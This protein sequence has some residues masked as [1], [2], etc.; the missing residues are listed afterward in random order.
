MPNSS[1]C[2][3]EEHLSKA[4]RTALIIT[5]TGWSNPN[6]K[7]SR[8]EGLSLF[9]DDFQVVERSQDDDAGEAAKEFGYHS[10]GIVALIQDEEWIGNLF[11]A[12]STVRPFDPRL[13]PVLQAFADQAAI[14]IANAR[15]F[16]DLDAALERQTAMTEVLDAVSTSRLDLQP[17]YDAVVHHANRLCNGTGAVIFV[18]DGEMLR[19]TASGGPSTGIVDRDLPIDDSTPASEAALTGRAVHIA[20]W[21]EVPADQYRDSPARLSGRRSVLTVPMLRNG[22]SVGVVGFSR[23]EPGGFTEA[24]ISLLQA[25]ANQ[26]A[27]AVDNARL[28]AELEQRNSE[29]SESLEL[30]TATS[31]ILE[32]I[33][34]NPGDLRTVLEGIVKKASG[35]CGA[36]DGHVVLRVD[37]AWRIEAIGNHPREWL[38]ARVPMVAANERASR[39][40]TPVFIDDW[41]VEVRDSPIEAASRQGGLRSF[42]TIALMQDDEWLGNLGLSRQE[43]RPFDAKHGVILQAFADQAAIAITNARLFRQL[44]EQ[45][46]IAEEANAAKGSFLATMS[47]EP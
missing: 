5:A 16:N 38:G 24:E 23:E 42:V 1:P 45:T 13:G 29:L 11:V 18:R 4:G 19:P 43:V 26:A 25:F 28:L 27:I 9:F 2:I 36:D 44:E 15:L 17:V 20:D 41:T 40:H 12:R 46:R 21:A 22:V 31:D 14:A 30:Q 37:G 8:D 39:E 35:L 32:L 33:S 10:L 3:F 34:A 6:A 7:S 47:H